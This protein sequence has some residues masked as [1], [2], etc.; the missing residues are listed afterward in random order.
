MT[1][2]ELTLT[3]DLLEARARRAL[4]VRSDDPAVVAAAEREVERCAAVAEALIEEAVGRAHTPPPPPLA[5][6]SS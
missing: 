2:F 6:S 5:C 1:S 4:A 3:L